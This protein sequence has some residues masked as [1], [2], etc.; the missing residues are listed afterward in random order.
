MQ[1]ENDKLK[2]NTVSLSRSVRRKQ[3]M[4]RKSTVKSVAC[5][6]IHSFKDAAVTD[7]KWIMCI[8]GRCMA[9]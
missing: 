3:E 2:E 9:A 8:C 7:Q 1:R 5:I 4:I 6:L